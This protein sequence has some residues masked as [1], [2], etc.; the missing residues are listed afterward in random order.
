MISSIANSVYE[1]IHELPNDLRLGIL[2]KKKIFGKSQIWME[3]YPS[4]HSPFQR[5]NPGHSSQKTRKSRYQTFLALSSVYCVSAFCSKYFVQDF[6]SLSRSF[7]H[8]RWRLTTE[9][10]TF[11]SFYHLLGGFENAQ[12]QTWVCVLQK[13]WFSKYCKI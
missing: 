7:L 6:S 8:G 4:A 1:L 11:V 10:P 2:G 9:I 3:T 13:K 5:L 12:K